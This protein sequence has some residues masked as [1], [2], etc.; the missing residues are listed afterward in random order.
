MPK[1][2]HILHVDDESK[3]MSLKQNSYRLQT[4]QILQNTYFGV[5]SVEME[6]VL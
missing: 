5:T 4:S 2:T 3:H 1:V 6:K